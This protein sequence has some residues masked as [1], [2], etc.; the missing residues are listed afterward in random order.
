MMELEEAQDARETYALERF[1][2]EANRR[3]S[4]LVE[5]ATAPEERLL[6]CVW[7]GRTDATRTVPVFGGP[8]TGNLRY[9]SRCCA[10]GVT[11]TSGIGHS[12][13]AQTCA[14]PIA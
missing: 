14:V 6:T 9:R 13:P 8:V 1:W 7:W 2:L 12:V 10:A 5:E 11:L 4:P 3:G